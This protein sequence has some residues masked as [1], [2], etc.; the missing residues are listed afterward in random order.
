MF[1]FCTEEKHLSTVSKDVFLL[2]RCFSSFAIK[3]ATSNVVGVRTLA[4]EHD[5]SFVRTTQAKR[6]A[7]RRTHAGQS[8]L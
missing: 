5:P 2:S 7:K 8:S 4:D 3:I 1:F 6:T